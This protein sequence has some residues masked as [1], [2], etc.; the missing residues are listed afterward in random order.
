MDGVGAE[1]R[2]GDF[3][4]LCGNTHLSYH[5]SGWPAT[6]LGPGGLARGSHEPA[7]QLTSLNEAQR[8]LV[9]DTEAELRKAHNSAHATLLRQVIKEV[10]DQIEWLQTQQHAQALADAAA[11]HART[12][13]PTSTTARRH[14][15]A[16]PD[17][18]RRPA[19]PAPPR[20]GRHPSPPGG[21]GVG[22]GVSLAQRGYEVRTGSPP[23][24]PPAPATQL[25]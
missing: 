17:P 14:R 7:Q 20:A 6:D 15:R 12:C 22:C 4:T 5:V 25:L 24:P 18:G 16:H 13:S 1:P 23:H 10:E 11:E 2:S 21:T 3:E 19:G 9:A 8:V